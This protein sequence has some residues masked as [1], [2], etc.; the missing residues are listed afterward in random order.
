[1]VKRKVSILLRI[2][3]IYYYDITS[4]QIDIKLHTNIPTDRDRELDIACTYNV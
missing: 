3:L 4:T 1:M 2:I